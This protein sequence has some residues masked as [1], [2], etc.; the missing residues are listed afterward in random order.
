MGVVNLKEAREQLEDLLARVDAGEDVAI[1]RE[2][3]A[4]VRLVLHPESGF[5]WQELKSFTDSLPKS[6]EDAATLVRLLRD[7]ARY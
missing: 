6:P 5:D 3:K 2:G 4:P 7:N 1:L